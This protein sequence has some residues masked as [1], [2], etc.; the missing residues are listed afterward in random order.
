[1]AL[2]FLL[3]QN[4]PK[5]ILNVS[6]VD[7][8]VEYVAVR[9]FDVSLTKG[10][11]PDWLIYLRAAE[12]GQFDGIVTRDRS[13]LDDAEELVALN[14]TGLSVV[15]WQRPVE[16]PIQEWGQLLSFMPLI[17]ARLEDER[18]LVFFLPKP[19]L[20]KGDNLKK[21]HAL[22]GLLASAEQR[23]F[24]ELRREARE[25]MRSELNSR[26]LQHL[27]GFLGP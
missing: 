14:D 18:P 22:L 23:S 26:S 3:D 8:T 2:R 24:G 25:F 27:A 13:Q 10:A 9:D 6:S 11:T 5:P 20:R 12:S 1:M 16:D 7:R 19:T 15:T 21:P 17:R 4:F